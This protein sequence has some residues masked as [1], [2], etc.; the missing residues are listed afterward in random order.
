LSN[1]IAKI[2]SFIVEPFYNLLCSGE[3]KRTKFIGAKILDAGDI[4]QTLSGWS[5]ISYGR[6]QIPL[7]SG[8]SL[9]I[10]P[11]FRKKSAETDK[12]IQAMDAAIGDMSI[13]CKPADSGRALYLITAPAKDI[14]MYIVK[15]LG[16]YLRDLAPNAIIRDGDYPRGSNAIEITVVFS[17]L[18][19]VEK[20]KRYYDKT[21]SFI[22]A[23]KDRQ[24]LQDN[25]SEMDDSS[26]DIP[27]LL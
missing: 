24:D 7:F 6:T 25:P 23:I 16:G 26:G 19:Y 22:S 14:N 18:T 3:E 17:E 8:L 20:I 12:G 10:L 11:N 4:I 15:E 21:A 9:G 2:N 27:S 13:K 5:V 1:N